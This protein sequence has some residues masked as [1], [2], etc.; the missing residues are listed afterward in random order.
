MVHIL[1]NRK[2]SCTVLLLIAASIPVAGQTAKDADPVAACALFVETFTEL[3]QLRLELLRFY[4]VVKQ[5]KNSELEMKV[6]ELRA[7]RERL[8]TEER[9]AVQHLSELDAQLP[10]ATA[11]ERERIEAEK[12]SRSGPALES[13]RARQASL[14][15][16]EDDLR[17][18][19]ASEQQRLTELKQQIVQASGT[20]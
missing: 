7:Q 19:L 12:A 1:F 8:D 16:R 5:E 9:R 18:L 17:S 15:R 20:R 4:A 11:E 3:K 13:L 2:L 10:S 6:N 14:G